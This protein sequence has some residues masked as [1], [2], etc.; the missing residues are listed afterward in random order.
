MSTLRSVLRRRSPAAFAALAVISAGVTIPLAGAQIPT[1]VFD[2]NERV[3]MMEAFGV[4]ANPVENFGFQVQRSTYA[5]RP[6]VQVIAVI[7]NTPAAKAG[8]K[9]GDTLIRSDGEPVEKI[10]EPGF[11][12]DA[13]WRGFYVPPTKRALLAAGQEDVTW[14]LEIR[15]HPPRGPTRTVTLTL[16]NPAPRWGAKIWAAPEGRAPAVVPEPGPLAARAK[17]IMDNGVWIMLREDLAHNLPR[18]S[19]YYGFQWSVAEGRTFIVSQARNRTD[20]ILQAGKTYYLSSPSG[21]LERVVRNEPVAQ[22]DPWKE[23]AL[24]EALPA[25][26]KEIDFWLR[27]VGKVSERWP[28]ELIGEGAAKPAAP[29]ALV[30][31]GVAPTPHLEAPPS[32]GRGPSSRVLSA[33]FLRLP[34]PTPAQRSLFD[35]ALGKIDDDEGRWA[36]TEWHRDPNAKKGLG[37]SVV[38]VDPSKPAAERFTLL[39]I[40]GRLPTP[41]ETAN[42]RKITG[43]RKTLDA[44]GDLPSL[45]SFLD[46]ENVRIASEENGSTVFEVALR[47]EK[48]LVFPPAVMRALVRIDGERR[49]VERIGVAT[50]DAVNADLSG[51]GTYGVRLTA[52]LEIVFQTIDPTYL[53]Q[54]VTLKLG[55]AGRVLFAKLA[56]LDRET[57][58]SDFRRVVP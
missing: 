26:E 28:L 24:P 20:I 45:N 48:D 32:P 23:I 6:I 22:L 37:Q 21:Q 51:Q 11:G 27:K 47:G 53:P 18:R 3:V 34:V 43:A 41:T 13:A 44:L 49:V 56:G 12:A 17:L 38:R 58:R 9:P 50:R 36:Y 40:N 2:E 7:P 46:L 19:Y 39:Q 16:P 30:S 57:T 35:E 29:A 4:R 31:P 55:G 1:R 52:G 15:S 54:P 42:W 33:H 10:R 8:L 5:G 25:F 14:T